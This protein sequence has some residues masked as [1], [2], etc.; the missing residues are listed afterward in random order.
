MIWNVLLQVACCV[1][2]RW[3]HKPGCSHVGT[4]RPGLSS[5]Q[6]EIRQGVGPVQST[7]LLL[8]LHLH[9]P[10]VHVDPGGGANSDGDPWRRRGLPAP[11][12]QSLRL[13]ADHLD[14]AGHSHTTFISPPSSAATR[15]RSTLWTQVGIAPGG[16]D[17]QGWGLQG[18]NLG[19]RHCFFAFRV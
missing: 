6:G 5:Q 10:A 3:N 8:L 2:K 11:P 15:P 12:L 14:C 18:G 1:Q 9:L 17:H 7:L 13:P 4:S 16:T 19:Q